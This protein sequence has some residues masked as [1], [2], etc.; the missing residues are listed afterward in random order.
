MASIESLGI[1]S[2]LLTTDLVDKIISAERKPTE[3]R[4]DRRQTSIEAKITAYGAFRS[5]LDKVRSGAAG[6]ADQNFIKSTTASSSNESALTATTGSNT[7]PGSYQ[8]AIDNV[9]TS[10][11]L[12]SKSYASVSD[13]L[14]T[15]S[16]TFK[17][18]TT[19]YDPATGDYNSFEQN[20][21]KVATTIELTSENNTL[22]GIRDTIN[23]EVAGVSASIVYDGTG[24]RMLLTS[25]ATGEKTSMEITVDGDAGLQALAYNATQNDPN[26][27]MD[28]TQQGEDAALR[29][30]G[31]EVTS[32]S[33]TLTK[34]I[35]GVTLNVKEATTSD[36]TLNIGR[37][38]GEVADRMEAFVTSYNEF[39]T[40][41]DELNKFDPDEQVGGLLLG[42][43][44]VRRAYNQVRSGMTAIV[45]NLTGADF[46]SLADVGLESDRE[47]NFLFK[48]DRTKFIAALNENADSMA[49][50]LANQQTITDS[51]IKYITK[52][53]DTQ[54]G[55][56]D[57]SI[58]QAASQAQ[59]TG[60]S[61][62][63]LGFAS[64]LVIGGGNDEF[65]ME[66]N[67]TS[68]TVT[69]EQ[70]SYSSGEDLALMLQ[71]S[72]NSAFAGTSHSISASFD[73][74]NQRLELTSSKFGSNS[75]INFTSVDPTLA[76][77]LGLTEAGYG[78]VAGQYYSHLDDAGF[79]AATPS[80][81]LAVAENE[82]I[83]FS[84][85][86]VSFDLTLGGTGA[87]DGTHS[88][89]LDENWSDI[90]DTDG[91]VTTDRDRTDVLAYVQ[92][93]L[94][95][96]G[97][98]GVVTAQFD[99]SDRLR[100]YTEPMAG[101]QTLDIGNIN[102]TGTDPL[103]L[104][105][106]GGTS[107]VTTLGSEFVISYSNRMSDAT[108][109]NIVVPDGTYETS[110]DLAA[111]IESAINADAAIQAGAAGATTTKGSRDL[112]G[113]IDFVA[114]PAQFQ[115]DLNGTDY[116]VDVTANGADNL[117]SIQQAIDATVGAGVVT[118]S[119]D[120]NGLVLS[121]NATGSAQRLEMTKD[122][123]G[124]TTD[125][126]T[127]DL[128]VGKNFSATPATFT[129]NVDGVD[130]N[131][132][133]D[134]DGT[135][136]TN[137]A[138]SN[139]SVIQQGLDNALS[140]A[141]GGGEFQAGDVVAR[142]DAS[143]RLYFETLSKNGTATE[144][145]YGA[146]A[147][148]Q[149]TNVDANAAAELGLSD[150]TT[151]I[152]GADGFG[153]DLG[154]YQGFDAQSTVTYEQDE[155]GNGRFSISFGNETQVQF[156]SVNDAAKTQL[157]FSTPTGK[158]GDAV[159][160][161]DVEG[162]INGFKAQGSGQYLTASDGSEVATS[163]Y[164]QG[165]AAADFTSAVNIDASNDNM[166]VV[167]DGVESGTISLTHGAYTTGDALAAEL[168]DQI[169]ADAAL[170]AAD[171]KVTVSYDEDTNKF[172]IESVNKGSDS[173]VSL[174][175]IDS[176]AIDVFGMTTTTA[177]VQGEDATDG[178]NPAAGLMLRIN[179]T[180]EGDRGSI[181]LIQG[182]FDKMNNTLKDMLGSSGLITQRELGLDKDLDSIDED[183]ERLETRIEA[184]EQRLKSKFLY[185]DQIISQLKTT[186][187]FLSQQFEILAAGITGK[188]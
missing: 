18:G 128:S 15:G 107:G 70:G 110:A 3:L 121:T 73:A 126:G 21:D 188:K 54:P 13:T 152:N 115:F 63:E 167:I 16:V 67:G 178:F 186:E 28:E 147:T 78:Q 132:T 80:G 151:T 157:G 32:E 153:I 119:L 27:N 91:N 71:N 116:T 183:R 123:K 85:N 173:S 100:F 160:G 51:Q 124:A 185:N 114:D 130:I 64:D 109:G 117:D 34:V 48:F 168:R 149:L 134:G 131:V 133:V 47:E 24:Y 96:A 83:D 154:L 143:N 172:T 36:L 31:L 56:Y 49:G 141:G 50:L 111:A 14:G 137:D 41:Y 42:D 174:S 55:T 118:A 84:E 58:S 136:G 120:A 44:A 9:A 181:T 106:G 8:I 103:G 98:N 45:E 158:E 102:V 57:I 37:N 43:S 92:S 40:V 38:S 26:S 76:S 142:L 112:S 77:T 52:T 59:W 155:T 146:D 29:I 88:I 170:V 159:T 62:D 108:S 122:G 7:S 148:V 65:T 150:Q 94:N 68:K 162:T 176:A 99:S 182:I 166:T 69:L 53:S 12:A 104:Q 113:A 164:L 22:T 140:S 33:N 5:V 161:T 46:R 79:G 129:L 101:A 135:Q 82:G 66:L 165:G 25:D 74:A 97:L 86:T 17:L 75:S 10:H 87:T 4:L 39:K 35:E 72:I 125:V 180:A 171:K 61:S 127:V 169:N 138:Q 23:K 179:G 163:G 30:N 139:L 187:D 1:G 11:S 89:T 60:L 20:P 6:L 144:G 175:A 95:N 90:I 105:V 19:S 81:T 184:M 93:E 156:D 177:G 2:G 145:T